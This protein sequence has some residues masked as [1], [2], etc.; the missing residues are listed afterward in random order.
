M[1]KRFFPGL[2]PIVGEERY[3]QITERYLEL[4]LTH[5][6]P[7]NRILEWHLTEGILPGL[8]FYQVLRETGESQKS[9]LSIIHKAFG[10]LFLENFN[11]FQKLG[12]LRF[13]Y[14]LLRVII[15]P[16]MR[17]YPLAGWRIA[18]KQ[19]DKDAIR[20]EM[21]SCFYFDVLLKYGAPEL[22]AAFCKVDD[23][24]YVNLFPNV[25]WQRTMT[26]AKGNTY[27]DF[28]FINNKK[29]SESLRMPTNETETVDRREII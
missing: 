1:S 12:K 18:W 22:T 25:V 7:Q 15:K 14:P 19:N 27:C 3:E 17:R 20:F 9:A 13:I 10:Q 4:Y 29:A 16:A 21:R 11:K 2:L 5:D 23:L 24:T 26:I 6:H 8:A 28:C